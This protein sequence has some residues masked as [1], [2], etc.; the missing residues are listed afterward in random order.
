MRIGGNLIAEMSDVRPQ[1][2][3]IDC[4]A[5][6]LGQTSVR[7]LLQRLKAPE[8]WQP[9]TITLPHTLVCRAST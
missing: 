4:S 7:L 8:S 6:T 1:L 3:T 5:R 9:Q 2:T